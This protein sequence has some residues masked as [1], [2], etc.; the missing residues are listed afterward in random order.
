M[1]LLPLILLCLS[2]VRGGGGGGETVPI[3]S[4]NF[5]FSTY[6][7]F[8]SST[9]EMVSA[10]P[11]AYAKIG[12][13]GSSFVL[14]VNTTRLSAT[15]ETVK[16]AFTIDDGAWQFLKL[17]RKA[18]P[19]A[20]PE[21]FLLASE[22]KLPNL[23]YARKQHDITVALYSSLNYPEIRDRWQGGSNGE[24]SYWPSLE[25]P[26]TSTPPAF[27]HHTCAASG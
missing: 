25:H 16:I 8:R 18:P 24:S 9:G 20:Q 4:P 6:N 22:L 12:F 2:L 3:D 19:T 27:H 26:W 5:Q 10:N 23:Q 21:S 11:G 7:W 1:L 15:V 14:L 17:Q 13:N